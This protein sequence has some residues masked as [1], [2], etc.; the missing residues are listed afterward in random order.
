MR[1][2]ATSGMAHQGQIT[3]RGIWCYRCRSCQMVFTSSQGLAGHQHKHMRQG[4]WIRGAPHH[5][6]FCPAAYFPALKRHLGNRKSTPTVLRGQGRFYRFRLRKPMVGPRRLPGRPRKIIDPSENAMVRVP[7]RPRGHPRTFN[8]L[9]QQQNAIV[10]ATKRPTHGRMPFFQQQERPPR[11]RMLFCQQ[12]QTIV[13]V[14]HRP[15]LGRL[16]YL[17]NQLQHQQTTVQVTHVTAHAPVTTLLFQAGLQAARPANQLVPDGFLRNLYAEFA[18]WRANQ[19]TQLSTATT[20]TVTVTADWMCGKKNDEEEVDE[21]DL[22]LR[23]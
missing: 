14:T 4:V 21:L 6:F 15:P 19:S 20:N 5:K 7:P 12:Q 2:P 8:Q 11:G 18:A 1:Q 13:Q 10:H 16:S 23:L 17:F 3:S 22:E 9:P